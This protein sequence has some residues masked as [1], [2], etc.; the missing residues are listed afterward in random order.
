MVNDPAINL[1]LTY[2]EVSAVLV[3][4]EGRIYK[5]SERSPADA[6]LRRLKSA[7]SSLIS[8]LDAKGLR[9]PWTRGRF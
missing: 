1:T 4:I 6:R 7:R 5:I 2:E 8:Q 9:P 3:A